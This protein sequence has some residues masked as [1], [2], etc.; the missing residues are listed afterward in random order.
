MI[1]YHNGNWEKKKTIIYILLELNG[2][3]FEQTRIPFNQECFVRSLIEISPVALGKK[4]FFNFVNVFL[5][6]GNYLPLEKGGAIYLNKLD[7]PSPKD[8]GQNLIRKALLTLQLRWAK[9]NSQLSF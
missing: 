5:L 3:S 4:I 7:S 6:F 1:D 9:N 8:N 2:S